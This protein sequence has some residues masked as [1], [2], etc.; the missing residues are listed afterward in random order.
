MSFML[1]SCVS[2]GNAAGCLSIDKF[3]LLLSLAILSV[4]WVEQFSWW[5]IQMVSAG[6]VD[7]DRLILPIAI[8]NWRAEILDWWA[9][10]A[11]WG[12][13]CVPISISAANRRRFSWLRR[14]RRSR[15]NWLVDWF[16][17]SNKLQQTACAKLMRTQTVNSITRS[18]HS[19]TMRMS[20][21]KWAE[22]NCCPLMRSSGLGACGKLPKIPRKILMKSDRGRR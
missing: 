20:L 12:S 15:L 7:L 18:R 5:A 4:G 9:Q 14:L 13:Q 6:R 10:M 11:F 2:V 3:E 16:K 19:L 22:F 17:Q 8:W 1:W 21:S